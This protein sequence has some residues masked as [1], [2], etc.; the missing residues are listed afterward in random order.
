MRFA[1]SNAT[2]ATHARKYVTKAMNEIKVRDKRSWRSWRNGCSNNYRQPPPLLV[3]WAVACL[4]GR[5]VRSV[6][7]VHC[8]TTLRCA[9]CVGD[10]NPA[11]LL[12]DRCLQACGPLVD[13]VLCY[14]YGWF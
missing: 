3:K 12:C 11:L 5:C 8:V 13:A 10:G 14:V 6:S 9:R 4:I 2:Y 1:G 7:C